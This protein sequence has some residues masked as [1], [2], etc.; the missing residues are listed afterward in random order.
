MKKIVLSLTVCSL[1]LMASNSLLK[2]A[3]N[4]GLKPIPQSKSELLKV[5][6]DPRNP[7]TQKKVKLGMEL[8]FDPRLSKSHLVSCNTCHNLLDGGDD[9]VS[10]AIGHKWRKNPH[11]LNSPTV[12][13][14]VFNKRQFWDG[15]SPDLE[16]QAQGPIQASP[17]MAA[18]KEHVLK[19]V[20]SIP[21]YVKE[22]NQA[23]PGKKITFK[24]IADTIGNF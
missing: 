12:Y 20:T 6:D 7:I 24:L 8:Y 3:K 9:G 15:R 10:A 1:S 23:Y 22:F 18:T 17:E 13:N 5:I 2:G 14:A 19:T 16:D 21:Q 4:A 11:H